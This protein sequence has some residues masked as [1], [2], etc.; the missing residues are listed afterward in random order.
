MFN[1]PPCFAIYVVGEVLKWLKQLGGVAAI[2]KIN[3]EKAG[4]LY[5]TIDHSDYY[6]GHAEKESRSLMNI[7]FNLPTKE[8]EAK[9][10]AEATAIDLNGLKGHRSVGGCRASL[11]NAFPMEG[12]VKLVE[13]MKEFEKRNPAA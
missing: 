3:I 12:V 10:I 4:L 6:R 7:T 5:A 1:T 13:F 2:E 8:L 11:Y 9:F